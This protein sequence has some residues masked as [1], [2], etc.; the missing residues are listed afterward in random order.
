MKS[1]TPMK[2]NSL[3]KSDRPRQSDKLMESDKP[4]KSDKLMKSDKPVKSN[5]PMRL[6]S[7]KPRISLANLDSISLENMK[8]LIKIGNLKKSKHLST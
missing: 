6:T 8:N 4:M 7:D 5:K 1:G 2:S 3:M